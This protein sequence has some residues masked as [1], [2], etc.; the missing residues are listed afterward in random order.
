MAHRV[1]YRSAWARCR[2]SPPA[3]SPPPRRDTKLYREAEAHAARIARRVARAPGRI[4]SCVAAHY[5]RVAALY[6][7]PAAPYCYTNDRHQPRYNFCI[8]THPWPGHACARTARPCAQVNRVA[9]LYRARGWP[10]H[11]HVARPITHPL[12]RIMAWCPCCVTIQY[13]VS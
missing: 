12:G 9:T 11:N 3:I 13:N 1:S 4:A 5:C 7:S 6:R 8:A 10:Y 2:R